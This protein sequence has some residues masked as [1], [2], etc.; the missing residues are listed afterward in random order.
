[1][2]PENE[3]GAPQLNF[4]LFLETLKVYLHEVWTRSQQEKARAKEGL[5]R[6]PLRPPRGQGRGRPG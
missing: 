1:M 2:E 3:F 5:H 6:S 4:A